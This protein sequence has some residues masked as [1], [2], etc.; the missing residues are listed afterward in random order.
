MLH[1]LTSAPE[2]VVRELIAFARG[3]VEPAPYD[4]PTW[5]STVLHIHEQDAEVLLSQLTRY[6]FEGI[7]KRKV[8]VGDPTFAM[9]AAAIERGSSGSPSGAAFVR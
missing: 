2:F 6:R 8:A 9:A 4:S 7:G 3:W 5:A 1:F